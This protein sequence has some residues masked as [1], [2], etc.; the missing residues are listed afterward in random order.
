MEYN[1]TQLTKLWVFEHWKG[2]QASDVWIHTLSF[3]FTL[4]KCVILRVNTPKGHSTLSE[5]NNMERFIGMIGM[6]ITYFR[7]TYLSEVL[8]IEKRGCLSLR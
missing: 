3:F 4:E 6:E 5:T 8:D 2:A 7:K 1:P